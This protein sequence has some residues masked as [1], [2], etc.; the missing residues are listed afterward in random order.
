MWETDSSYLFVGGKYY[1]KKDLGMSATT[2]PKNVTHPFNE[3]KLMDLYDLFNVKN[4]PR[5]ENGK[6]RH[7]WDLK[8]EITHAADLNKLCLD[9]R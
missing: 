3:E 6:L 9:D 5:D 1:A 2:D 4:P 8:R 7:I